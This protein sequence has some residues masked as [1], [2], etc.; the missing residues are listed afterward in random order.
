MT[1]GLPGTVARGRRFPALLPVWLPGEL[2]GRPAHGSA[3]PSPASISILPATIELAALGDT[4]RLA[5]EVRDQNG[6]AMPEAGVTW[7]SSV[8]TVATVDATGLV[9]AAGNGTAVV[10]ASAGP[11]AGSAAVTA[12]QAPA[13]VSLVPGSLVF[14]AAGETAPLIVAAADAN[15]HPIEGVQ[16][17]W[18]SRDVA[19][20][21]VD[22]TGLVTAVAAGR[23]EVNARVGGHEASAAVIVAFHAVSILL[24]RPEL[25]F[26]ALGDTAT[27]TATAVDRRGRAG[28][29]FSIRWTSM[30]GAE[31]DFREAVFAAREISLG[32]GVVMGGVGVIIPPGVGAEWAGIALM[33]GVTTSERTGPPAPEGPVRTDRRTRLHGR[34]GHRGGAAG[35]ERPGSPE[36]P[37]DR[38]GSAPETRPGDGAG[39]DFAPG[40]AAGVTL[41]ARGAGGRRVAP[42]TGG[43]RTEDPTRRVHR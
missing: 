11:L 1:S 31:L 28:G 41:G 33:G 24:D 5:A 3:G 8:A 39:T 40:H 4:A 36:A 30:G 18:A 12:R 22:T 9:T 23:T 25:S 27:L 20:A 7:S 6:D 13:T 17:S 15:G 10:T 43:C 37:E 2:L 38:E 21:T 34:R 16:V 32:V 19:V 35:R 42:P 14:E 26:A 29:A